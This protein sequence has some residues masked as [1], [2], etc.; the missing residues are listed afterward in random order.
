MASYPTARGTASVVHGASNPAVLLTLE[1]RARGA[2]LCVLSEQKALL[3]RVAGV[4]IRMCIFALTGGM[5]EET[6]TSKHRQPLHFGNICVV[7]TSSE[8]AAMLV[9]FVLPW[10]LGET[11]GDPE[12]R[13]PL[14]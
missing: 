11:S 7:K 12:K 3:E 9:D 2:V 1:D 8:G 6:P 4:I 10:R 13:A 5:T 14:R